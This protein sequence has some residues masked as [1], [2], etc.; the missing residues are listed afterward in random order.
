MTKTGPLT[1]KVALITGGDTGI[2]KSIAKTL[3]GQGARVV[4]QHPH[5]P[6]SAADVVKE[7]THAGGSALALAADI[8]DRAEYE[9]L[10]Q[11]MLD[12]CGHWDVLVQTT[13]AIT[14]PLREVSDEDFDLGFVAPAKAVFY[15][16]QLAAT[17]LSDGGRIITVGRC[18]APGNAVDNAAMSAIAA[19]TRALAADFAPRRITVNAVSHG[20]AANLAEKAEHETS[21]AAGTK[22]LDRVNA[23][24]EITEAVALLVSDDAEAVTAEYLRV[25][26]GTA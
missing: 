22:F 4:I 9:E 18:T 23:S 14:A 12:E 3:A 26:G 15:G 17:H 19:F 11:A 7:I 24:T 10:I 21:Y 6:E 20:A 5:A 1:G 8:G 16:I 25:G 13:A 2:G